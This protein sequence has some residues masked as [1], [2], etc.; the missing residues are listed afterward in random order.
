MMMT[1]YCVFSQLIDGATLINRMWNLRCIMSS[2]PESTRS[3]GAWHLKSQIDIA[4]RDIARKSTNT[5]EILLLFSVPKHF[6]LLEL[7]VVFEFDA[8]GE[9]FFLFTVVRKLLKRL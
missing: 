8:S 2:G 4:L 3:F 6:N 1:N 5:L 7:S 9:P